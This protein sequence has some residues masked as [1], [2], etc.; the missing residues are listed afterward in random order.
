MDPGQYLARVFSPSHQ[1][2]PLNPVRLVAD[3]EDARARCRSDV[4]PAQVADEYRHPIGSRDHD[5]LDVGDRLNEA[6]SPDDES[7]LLIVEK[8]AARVLIVRIDSLGDVA[9]SEVVFRQRR[10]I[11]FDLILLDHAPERSDIGDTRH[12]QQSRLDDPI[13]DFS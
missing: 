5:V 4:D 12:L 7:L 9:N 2:D 11:D 10:R 3:C 8:R 13:L 1:D 6:D